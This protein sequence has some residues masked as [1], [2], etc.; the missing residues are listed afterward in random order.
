MQ[1]TIL[2][3]GIKYNNRCSR[4]FHKAVKVLKILSDKKK[5]TVHVSEAGGISREPEMINLKML[6]KQISDP[7]QERMFENLGGSVC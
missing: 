7:A 1:M 4:V 6:I 5:K 3:Y 2:L